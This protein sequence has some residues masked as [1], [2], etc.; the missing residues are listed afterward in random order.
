MKGLVNH[1]RFSGSVAFLAAMVVLITVDSCQEIKFEPDDMLYLTT[2]SVRSVDE[3]VYL[4]KGSLIHIGQEAI[5]E[6]GF[7]WSDT[8]SPVRDGSSIL[9][10][11]RDSIGFF[12]A[13][14]SDLSLRTT[15]YV[16]SFVETETGITYGNEIYFRTPPPHVDPTMTDIDG[17]IY[18][19]VVIGIQAWMAENLRTTHYADG[20]AI[21][22]VEDDSVWGALTPDAK[23]FSWYEN[24][25]SNGDYGGY[26]TW[27]AA[28]N[29]EN[30]SNRNPSRVQG[31]CPDGWHLPSDA[32]WNQMQIYLGMN[33]NEANNYGF[34]GTRQSIG[35]KL[36]GVGDPLWEEY[37]AYQQYNESG[38]TALPCGLRTT[39][40][41][42][43]N[44]QRY[45]YFWTS[46]EFDGNESW[47]RYLQ[48][49]HSAVLRVH[50]SKL[51]GFSV[52]CVL[53]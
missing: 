18:P 2:D 31:V 36:K 17:N 42:F 53:D 22:M 26:Y 46:T 40:G 50:N 21:P 29:G 19:V 3:N 9:L 25:P 4:M 37:R 27:A 33:P 30:G 8:G 6:H 44:L 34:V 1:R 15:Y 32:E 23:A 14:V 48:R 12:T 38:F 49:G 51:H 5:T 10:G 11:S 7:C 28:M 39:S 20:S 13:V 41:S 43:D 24:D 52:R 35:I 16:K 45:A 47:Y